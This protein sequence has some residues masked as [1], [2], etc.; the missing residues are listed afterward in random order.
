ML[1][2]T[3]CP[4]IFTVPHTGSRAITHN[5]AQLTTQ[6]HPSMQPGT[7]FLILHTQ[8]TDGCCQERGDG[9]EQLTGVQQALCGAH[10]ALLLRNQVGNVV[11]HA[12]TWLRSRRAL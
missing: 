8:A 4:L 5:L 1:L 7:T 10:S 9:T 6:T 12:I 2:L 11:D 3:A